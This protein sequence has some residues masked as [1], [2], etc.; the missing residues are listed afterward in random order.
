MSNLYRGPSIDAFYQVWDQLFLRFQ[1]RRLKC[2]KLTDDGR[3]VM[4]KAHIAFDKVSLK[5][6]E[7]RIPSGKLKS[8][9]R[10][11][12]SSMAWLTVTEYVTSD[13]GY[14]PFAII[15][16]QPF[17]H[18][19]LV[20]KFL[21]WVERQVP[22]VE[23]ELLTLPEHWSSLLFFNGAYVPQFFVFCVVFCRPTFVFDPFSI[24]HY[25][26]IVHVSSVLRMMASDY[27]FTSCGT[28]VLNRLL[29]FL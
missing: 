19:W 12:Y 21:T 27:P 16:T 23:Q 24:G 4:A 25:I 7:R 8:T 17:S 3:Q 14:V 5:T 13:Q 2:E 28:V 9:L 6:T 15:K 22:P 10:K 11:S 1:R 26:Y 20:I 18:V 29:F